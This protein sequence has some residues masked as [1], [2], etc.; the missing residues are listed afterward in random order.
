MAQ[1]ELYL[2]FLKAVCM[3]C[4]TSTFHSFVDVVFGTDRN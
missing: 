3:C 1:I 2:K 4:L